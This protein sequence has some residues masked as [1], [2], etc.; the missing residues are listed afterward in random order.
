ML[1]RKLLQLRPFVALA[2]L[3]LV[4]TIAP[5]AIKS[6]LRFSF[7]EFQAP[8]PTGV[9][10]IR[11]LQDYW[12]ARLHSKQELYEAGQDL[13]RLNAAYEMAIVQNQ[14]LKQELARMEKLLQLPS[15]TNYQY[16]IAR[17]AER[18]FNSWWQR[19]VIRKGRNYRIQVN[20]P[21][22]FVGGVVGVVK[23]VHQYTSTVD[24]ISNAHLRIAALI[25]GDNRVVSFHG[26]GSQLFA[27]PIGLAEYVPN[28][29]RITDTRN[30]P[31]LI[32]SGMGGIFPPGL[33]L[34]YIVKLRQGAGGM[35]LDATVELD[36]RLM[37]LTEVAVLVPLER[38]WKEAADP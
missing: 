36:P 18:D 23:E 19:I 27:R 15:R 28:D 35:F 38:A 32:T 29:I 7:Y 12:A 26:Q 2:A 6:A 22:V 34:G 1:K 14:V 33:H 10:Y 5:V 30:P 37:T 20:D 21:V 3:I 16:E 24:L 17:V 8:L 11:D 31:R 13:A 25:E 4:W 9:S